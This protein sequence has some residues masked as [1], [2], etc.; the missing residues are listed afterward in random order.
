MYKP[1]L[2]KKISLAVE[3]SLMIHRVGLSFLLQYTSFYFVQCFNG[4]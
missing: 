2:N 3:T 1:E 4:E